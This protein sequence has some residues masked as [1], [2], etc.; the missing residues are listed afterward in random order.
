MVKALVW[1]TREPG[2]KSRRPDHTV[3]ATVLA[4]TVYA[5]ISCG[6]VLAAPVMALREYL[7]R[8]LYGEDLGGYFR[9]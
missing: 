1:G 4:A 8:C 9:I 3:C 2:F 5:A 7:A 6:T